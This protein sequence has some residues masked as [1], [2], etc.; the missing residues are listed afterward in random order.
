M[1]VT[2]NGAI[3]DRPSGLPSA[4]KV[5]REIGSGGE[6]RVCEVVGLPDLVAK[7]YHTPP[8]PERQEKLRRMAKMDVGPLRE[9]AAWPI[10]VIAVKAGVVGGFVMQRISGHEDVHFLYGP[11]S[12]RE[13]FPDADFRFVVRA[14]S[15]IAKTFATAHAAGVVIGDVNFGGI[16]VS[17]QATVK[18][19]DCDS[20]QIEDN[21]KVYHCSV[22]MPQF[23]PPEIVGQPL[24]TTKRTPNHDN[25][26]LAVLI[27]HLLMMGR[28]PFAGRFTGYGEMPLEK[29]IADFRYAY[30]PRAAAMQMAPPPGVPPVAR[31]AGQA[32]AD[33]FEKAFD[34]K[35]PSG[36]RPD[37][38]QWAEL[39][40]GLHDSL[41]QCSLNR[42]H[43][44]IDGDNCPWCEAEEASGV[45][46]FGKATDI[47]GAG[48]ASATDL[49]RAVAAAL[50][51]KLPEAEQLPEPV[52]VAARV[53]YPKLQLI[54]KVAVILGGYALASQT[55]WFW[56]V[57]FL[58]YWFG[59]RLIK[60]LFARRW[61]Q[62][63]RRK[64]LV[65]QI[66]AEEAS[67][68]SALRIY[69]DMCAE[70]E[71]DFAHRRIQ[72]A[73][74]YD[75]WQNLPKLRASR[76]HWIHNNQPQVQLLKYLRQFPIQDAE[77]PHI[78]K[79]RKLTLLTSGY[80]TAA[81]LHDE[82]DDELPGFGPHLVDVMLTWQEQLSAGFVYD[83]NLGVDKADLDEV[84]AEIE[85]A[86]RNHEA[87]LL[88]AKSS[89]E[90]TRDVYMQRRKIA[91]DHVAER[92]DA[93]SRI[94]AELS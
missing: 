67:R 2:D 36:S 30:G 86:M 15:N 57:W 52:P 31:V 51:V 35:G 58:S 59:N 93:I 81:D 48:L 9:L 63:R 20:F 46:M 43:W 23:T 45:A 6:G 84:R 94:N 78:G 70:Q 90:R 37:A 83:P 24:E 29:A 8:S 54:A 88:Q 19:L 25:F 10:D 80:L 42:A 40:D 50:N 87:Q 66:V 91:A 76:L 82:M 21:G 56:T 85:D 38:R 89:L 65:R 28:H 13:K 49:A 7:I 5:G 27:F 32:I 3:V 34:M 55:T 92:T 1:T 79:T 4:M 16:T 75:R 17:R 61:F 62:R 71:M 72:I 73:R 41:C 60:R 39:L 44:V 74:I 22:A 53:N 47:I 68:K 11:K 18:L 77:I 14:A 26:G 12:R 33:A 69:E 64:E